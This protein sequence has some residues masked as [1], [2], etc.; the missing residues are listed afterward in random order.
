MAL[1][2]VLNQINLETEAAAEYLVRAALEDRERWWR[3][4]ELKDR[5]K[6]PYSAAIIGMALDQ[7]LINGVFEL[8]KDM[9][10]DKLIRLVWNY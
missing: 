6:Y 2:H 5:I 9:F 7:L 1:Q 8:H 3:V 4:S 10:K